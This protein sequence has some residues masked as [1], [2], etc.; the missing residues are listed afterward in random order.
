M[1][2]KARE[3]ESVD[4]GFWG[5]GLPIGFCDSPILNTEFSAKVPEVGVLLPE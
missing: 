3:E 4:G 5:S 1:G 2:G